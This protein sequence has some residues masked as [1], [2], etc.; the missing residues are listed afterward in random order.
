MKAFAKLLWVWAILAIAAGCASRGV[1]QAPPV[2]TPPAPVA[3][4]PPPLPE[5]LAVQI[6]QQPAAAVP[7]QLYS[8][9]VTD[10]DI[11]DVLLTLGK[12]TD[13]SF[14]LGQGVEGMVTVDLKQVTLEE[15]LNSMLSPV[16][17]VYQREG[18]LIRVSRP[19]LT[20]RVF[21]VN[22][23]MSTRTGTAGLSATAGASG[24]GG[25][26]GGAGGGAAGAGGG[27]SG[28]GSTS[29]VGST[30]NFDFWGELQR[31]LATFLSMQGRLMI[32]QTAGLVAVTDYPENINQAANYIE[33][34]Q[35]AVQRQVVIEAKI[36]EVSLN[37]TYSAGI[38]W[39]LVPDTLN[40]PP[41]IRPRGTLPGRAIAALNAA[42]A[43]SVFQIGLGLQGITALI[44]ALE[45]QGE[46]SILSSPKVSTLNNQKAI[47]KVAT[48]DVFFTQTTQRE[49]LTGVVTQ[50]V[51]PNTI[52]E[53]IVLDVTP[54]IGEDTITMNIRPSISER[55]G[56]ATSPTG[57][58]VPILAVRATDTVVRV[59]DGQTVVI[60]GLMSQRSTKTRN[61]IP[62]L[63]R[64]P[65]VGRAFRNDDEGEVKVELVILLTPTLVVGRGDTDLTPRE[66]ELLRQ[67]GTISRR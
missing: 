24:G 23:I 20:T 46:V 1:A 25:G 14:V 3:A 30:D 62:G 22:Y 16:G 38:N 65:V 27:G 11:R 61:G 10:A 58:I 26:G 64:T 44:A 29:S 63:Q 48:D 6:E 9:A 33:L 53:G 35:G 59:R 15:M 60:G 57:D 32:S 17:L 52:T 37:K 45:R 66:L 31:T 43:S 36:L 67:A 55:L 34:V 12:T 49:P 47:I 42:P 2:P 51:T 41:A 50:T 5:L 39:S 4:A 19:Q 8:I 18:N 13:L 21:T 7:R 54:Q 56:S 40:V 28:G